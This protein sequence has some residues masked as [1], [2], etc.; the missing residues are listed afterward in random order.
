MGWREVAEIRRTST[1]KKHAL[2]VKR[3]SLLREEEAFRKTKIKSSEDAHKA[4]IASI[5]KWFK[6]EMQMEAE[7]V[8]DA[9]VGAQR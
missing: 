3:D 5:W 9:I 7:Y 4:E 6:D 8:A 2:V 1:I